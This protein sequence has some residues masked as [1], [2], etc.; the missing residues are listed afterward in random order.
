MRS[1]QTM[2]GV[3][4]Q[5][6][7]RMD[8]HVPDD[9]GPASRRVSVLR[10]LGQS[11]QLRRRVRRAGQSEVRRGRSVRGRGTEFYANAGTGLSQ[12]RRARRR[13]S[14]RPGDAAIR[15]IRVT[16]LVRARGAE[17]GL[18]TVRIRGLQSTVALW[19]LGLDSELLFV[20][21]AGTTE[22]GR[23]SR[24]VRRRVDQLRATDAVA[25]RRWRSRALA[26][27]VQRRRSGRRRHPGRARSGRFPAGLTVE[28]RPAAVRQPSRAP[29]RSAAADRRRQRELEEHD[30]LERRAR[31]SRV[32][33]GAPGA[34]AVQ[35]LRRR[36]SPISTTS[37]PRGCRGT[38]SR[39][40]RHPHIIR[41]CRDRSEWDCS[42]RFEEKLTYHMGSLEESPEAAKA[43][44]T[45]AGFT[46]R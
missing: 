40:G 46:C 13:D 19:Y 33:Q 39:H 9:A 2:G 8:A 17:V 31:L 36:R 1:D 27:S 23:P 35:H 12:Q 22:A 26:R 4:A 45:F 18:R 6:R 25:D 5:T 37:T 29:L 10:H 3:Y 20:G 16:P 11:A 28:P 34:R 30:A 14:R 44:P 7:D 15:S 38:A 24:R 21:D 41:R 43:R 42:C 32:Q